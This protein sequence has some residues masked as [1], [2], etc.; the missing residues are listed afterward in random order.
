MEHLHCRT[1]RSNTTRITVCV[2]VHID[3]YVSR[4]ITPITAL[5]C[6]IRY[7]CPW[8]FATRA[9]A[10]HTRAEKISASC[11]RV[12]RSRVYCFAVWRELPCLCGTPAHARKHTF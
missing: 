12:L 6:L 10:L 8:Y 9:T 3:Q 4:I 7:I 11:A 2:C 1:C 5:T